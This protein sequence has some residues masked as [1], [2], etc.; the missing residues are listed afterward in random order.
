MDDIKHFLGASILA[1]LTV[2]GGAFLLAVVILQDPAKGWRDN[3]LLLKFRGTERREAE[4]GFRLDKFKENSLLLTLA[5][6]LIYPV[7]D[8]TLHVLDDVFEDS[9]IQTCFEKAGLYCRGGGPGCK[10]PTTAGCPGGGAPIAGTENDITLRRWH[11]YLHL[12]E[13]GEKLKFTRIGEI[14]AREDQIDREVIDKEKSYLQVLHIFLL[15]LTVISLALIIYASKAR[16]LRII[17]LASAAAV[18]ILLSRRGHLDAEPVVIGAA[19]AAALI[20]HAGWALYRGAAS[21]PKRGEVTDAPPPGSDPA[22]AEPRFSRKAIRGW[23]SWQVIRGRLGDS[24][25]W[26]PLLA[27]SLLALSLGLMSETFKEYEE[28]ED[29]YER[30]VFRVWKNHMD[31]KLNDRKNGDEAARSSA[32]RS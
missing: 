3:K 6:I 9:F 26:K 21:R 28:Q 23:L 20:I 14:E 15:L 16:V 31:E 10:P 13:G 4:A 18:A 30:L 27:C 19:I 7:G 22:T 5:V 8:A 29:K 1:G 2:I 12:S 11:E 32:P 24:A 25:L 17:F